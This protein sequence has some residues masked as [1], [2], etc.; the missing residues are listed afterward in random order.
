MG[1]QPQVELG[2]GGMDANWFNLRG[3][4]SVGIATGYFKNHTPEE[5]LYL[6]DFQKAGELVCRLIEAYG[7][8]ES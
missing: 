5:H 3:I 8:L 1:I 4:A 6:E 7:R 2:G